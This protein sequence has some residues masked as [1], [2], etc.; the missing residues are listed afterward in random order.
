MPKDVSPASLLLTTALFITVTHLRPTLHQRICIKEVE[1]SLSARLTSAQ[2]F[3]IMTNV[4][5]NL[6]CLMQRDEEVGDSVTFRHT[7]LWELAT[8]SLTRMDQLNL[9][10]H[11]QIKPPSPKLS[12]QVITNLENMHGLVYQLILLVTDWD[13]I[14]YGRTTFQIIGLQN[15]GARTLAPLTPGSCCEPWPNVTMWTELHERHRCRE[16]RWY[17]VTSQLS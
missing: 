10:W 9:K 12:F 3:M 16:Y 15:K 4:C 17:F 2:I 6:W 5:D 13:Y 14:H 11:N 8:G 1:R 7:S